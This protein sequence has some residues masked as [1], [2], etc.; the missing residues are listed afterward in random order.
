M[1]MSGHI[2]ICVCVCGYACV[3]VCAPMSVYGR[4]SETLLCR[5]SFGFS[6]SQVWMWELDHKEGWMPK[7]WCFWAVMLE[8]TLESPLNCKEIKP[9]NPKENQSWILIGRTDAEVPTLWPPDAKS[10]LLRK[11]PD[12]GKDWRQKEKGT[13]EDEMVGWRHWC[14]G[15]GLSK[16]QETVKDREAWH[17]A[18]PG[19]TK[20]WTWLSDWTTIIGRV[21]GQTKRE[22]RHWYN[23]VDKSLRFR[24]WLWNS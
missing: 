11:D 4:G 18:V 1:N 20:S 17:A 6:S 14:N 24:S 5:Q 2:H 22:K 21:Q 7:N 13:T 12:A 10:W 23:F 3:C 15:H 8:K 19:V 9:L 16:L